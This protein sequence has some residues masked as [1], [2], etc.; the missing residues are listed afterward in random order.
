MERT[1]LSGLEGHLLLLPIYDRD[2][3]D[4]PGPGNYKRNDKTS[5]IDNNQT[6]YGWSYFYNWNGMHDWVFVMNLY[7]TDKVADLN[8]YI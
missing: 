1:Q 7:Y 8:S 6:G 4:F 5:S 3:I 2:S